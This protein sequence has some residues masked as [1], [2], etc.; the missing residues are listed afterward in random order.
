MGG[1]T[2]GY[3]LCTIYMSSMVCFAC[4]LTELPNSEYINPVSLKFKVQ[5]Y[6]FMSISVAVVFDS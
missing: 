1:Y 4:L 3:Y 5:F 6:L 2:V